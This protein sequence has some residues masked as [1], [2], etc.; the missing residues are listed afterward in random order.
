MRLPLQAR[1]VRT[2]S[3]QESVRGNGVLI[4]PLAARERSG[5]V[6][7]TGDYCGPGHYE[8]VCTNDSYCCDIGWTCT[9]VDGTHECIPP[10]N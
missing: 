9:C 5:G 1:S 10:P 3:H 6:P 8:C 4:I 2:R 7:K